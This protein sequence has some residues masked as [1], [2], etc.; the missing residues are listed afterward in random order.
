[1]VVITSPGTTWA[2]QLVGRFFLWLG[3]LAGVQG[4]CR[5]LFVRD[6]VEVIQTT[7]R[8]SSDI[9]NQR[10]NAGEFLVYNTPF[11]TLLTCTPKPG[12]NQHAYT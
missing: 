12:K 7:G 8:V 6:L 4:R 10:L 5:A 11:A 1:M 2:A 3:V 9:N